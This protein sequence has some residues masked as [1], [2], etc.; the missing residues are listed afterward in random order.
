M[1]NRCQKF[2]FGPINEDEKNKKQNHYSFTESEQKLDEKN[3]VNALKLDC[4]K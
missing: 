3:L 4:D 1:H 2:F